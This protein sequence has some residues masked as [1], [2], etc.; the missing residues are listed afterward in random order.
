MIKAVSPSPIHF[1]NFP[2]SNAE[3]PLPSSCVFIPNPEL[4]SGTSLESAASAFLLLARVCGSGVTWNRGS[5]EP[6]PFLVNLSCSLSSNHIHLESEQAHC[7]PISFPG[8]SPT[9]AAIHLSVPSSH[10][11][12][13]PLKVSE[14]GGS[15][16]HF[17]ALSCLG[18]YP[19]GHSVSR[20]LV[21]TGF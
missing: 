3:S 15:Q 21:H 17:L 19:Q 18:A 9:P 2:Q 6:C 7:L 5:M 20:H 10:H 1:Y 12:G 11:W 4:P 16:P 8:R 13:I 14:C